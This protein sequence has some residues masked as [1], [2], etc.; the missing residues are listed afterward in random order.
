MIALH[1]SSIMEDEGRFVCPVA[2]QFI[3]PHVIMQIIARNIAAQFIALEKENAT[4]GPLSRMRSRGESARS[5][6]W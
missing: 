4:H 3:A 2:A 1:A 6:D 5:H